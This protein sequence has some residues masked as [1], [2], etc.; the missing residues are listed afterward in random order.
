MGSDSSMASA[1]ALCLQ[2]SRWKGQWDWRLERRERETGREE[3]EKGEGGASFPSLDAKKETEKETE[4]KKKTPSLKREVSG[5][6]FWHARQQYQAVLH[7]EQRSSLSV[8]PQFP[9]ENKGEN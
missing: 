6:T 3:R 9:G 8:S 2:S 1:K 4:R 7:L 5:R